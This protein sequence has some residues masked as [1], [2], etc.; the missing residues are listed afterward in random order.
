MSLLLLP[1][2]FVLP[3]L[4]GWLLLQRLER[5]AAVLYNWERWIVSLALGTVLT[6]YVT[7][8]IHV[9]SG[10]PFNLFGF[11][12][13]QLVLLGVAF[14]LNGRKW[15]TLSAA[16]IQEPHDEP[17]PT[18]LKVL[19]IIVGV[20][21]ALKLIAG[22]IFLVGSP[23]FFD[24]VVNNWNMR[25]K[26]YFIQKALV[27]HTGSDGGVGVGSYPPTVPMMKAWLS[28][29]AF[30]WH[31]PLIRSIHIVWYLCNLGTVF[32]VL[33]RLVPLRWAIAGLY[34]IASVPLYFMHGVVP[35]ADGFLSLHIFLSVAYLFL[36][37]RESGARRSALFSIAA[38]A[39]GLLVFT[40]SEAVLLHLPPIA[41][42]IVLSLI[43][44][45]KAGSMEFS[46]V[47]SI[48]IRYACAVAAVAI[49]WLLFKWT[50]SLDFGN[51]KSV[52]GL[53]IEWHEGVLLSM[54]L[55]TFFEGN[56][57]YL[58]PLLFMLI[59]WQWKKAFLSPLLIP[60]GFVLMVII[61]QMPIYLFTPLATE[62][63]QQTGYARG[64]I[65]LVPL[66]I[67]VVMTLLYESVGSGKM[68]DES[69]T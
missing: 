33:R 37:T 66:V 21:L 3:T 61:G 65:H 34:T 35:Y 7:F 14:Q 41:V 30:G 32:F 25:G 6:M 4:V 69:G 20:W 9:L 2:G 26:M 40:K 17:W 29:L 62:V 45:R 49:P 54:W 42:L 51:A 46:E 36:A 64:L 8:F 16:T 27:I 59:V 31:E 10:L 48:I 58:F 50:N 67:L 44:L 47:R 43:L 38:L 19:C 28:S 12:A 60:L 1:V 57:A 23:P 63:L 39:T 22:F 13:V 68:K 24:D 5:Q 15:N 56:W 55:N 53:A 11:L 18:W 52:S